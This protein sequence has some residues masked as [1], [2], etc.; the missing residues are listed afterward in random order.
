MRKEGKVNMTL[1]RYIE[2]K[3]YGDTVDQIPE[4]ACV[5]GWRNLAWE[6]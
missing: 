3:R 2:A 1:T 6:G 4:K 5:N